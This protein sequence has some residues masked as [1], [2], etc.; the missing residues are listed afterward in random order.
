V[1]RE[2]GI[3][4][5]RT[6]GRNE[7][8]WHLVS[9][10]LQPDWYDALGFPD[11]LENPIHGWHDCVIRDEVLGWDDVDRYVESVR[12]YIDRVSAED[13]VF[14]LC[15]HDWS[16]IRADPRMRATE[17]L[18]QY[19]QEQGLRFMSYRAFPTHAKTNGASAAS[20]PRRFIHRA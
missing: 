13:K 9:L 6:D 10:D 11:M 17:A 1:L 12:P 16:S 14:S 5:T 2:G 3:R 18:I 4:L 8:D 20:P 7:R 19:V 15:Q